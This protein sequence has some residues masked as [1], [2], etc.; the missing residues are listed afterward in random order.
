MSRIHEAIL[1]ASTL[2]ECECYFGSLSRITLNCQ[3][4]I[5]RSECGAE[6][7]KPYSVEKENINSDKK[8]EYCSSRLISSSNYHKQ[9]IQKQH[10]TVVFWFGWLFCLTNPTRHS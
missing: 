4:C 7:A 3:E 2:G 6:T 5:K 8:L 9:T 10:Y 1:I